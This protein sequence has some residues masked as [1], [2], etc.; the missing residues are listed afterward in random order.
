MSGEHYFSENPSSANQRSTVEL[1]LGGQRVS[2][3]TA[4]GTFSASGL[5]RG[6][7]VLLRLAPPPPPT[8]VFV[9]LGCGWGPIAL[10]L[11]LS[12]PGATIWA[13][14]VNQRALELLEDNGQALSL[15]TIRAVTPE[16]YPQDQGVDLLWSNPPIRIGK[17]ALH[18]L[19]TTWLNRL[20]PEGEA[21]LVVS[22]NLGADSLMKWI[23]NGGA[24]GFECHRVD[25]DKGFRV[26]RVRR[27]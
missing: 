21:W 12:S 9:D 19:L 26:L 4:K 16:N 6:T 5:D 1:L 14:D 27:L 24:G 17:A 7:E 20:N 11:A 2:V 23:N 25:T 18:E 10:H 22:K 8:G 13:I 15:D 3:H